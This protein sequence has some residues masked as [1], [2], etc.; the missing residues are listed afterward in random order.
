MKASGDRPAAR[1]AER[2]LVP[3]YRGS[4]ACE[5]RIH[6]GRGHDRGAVHRIDQQPLAT[7]ADARTQMPNAEHRRRGR[8]R[9]DAARRGGGQRDR[10][11]GEAVKGL[12]R[13][14][15]R[16]QRPARAAAHDA[17][18][19]HVGV[20]Y[21]RGVGTLRPGDLRQHR[22][23]PGCRDLRG[24]DIAGVDRQQPICQDEQVGKLGIHLKRDQPCLTWQGC[25]V[26]QAWPAGHAAGRLDE[27]VA[28][29]PRAHLVSAQ[30]HA[31]QQLWRQLAGGERRLGAE[32]RAHDRP[33]TE[34]S[35]YSSIAR[36]VPCWL[37]VCRA[38]RNSAS[39]S[40]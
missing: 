20:Q 33:R 40:L 36:G 7:N 21:Q 6:H 32:G 3:D 31:A 35:G 1:I 23:G 19:R 34:I 14:R 8:D 17:L 4:R 30:I 2:R 29:A 28:Q 13:Q 9:D 22:A 16:C 25:D 38:V 18:R 15:P 37:S 12:P 39:A 27:H 26:A 10:T 24:A 11:I 5:R